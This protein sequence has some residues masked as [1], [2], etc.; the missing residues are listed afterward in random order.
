MAA[1]YN[2][3]SPSHITNVSEKGFTEVYAKKRGK[4]PV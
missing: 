4:I 3:L 2:L 1:P